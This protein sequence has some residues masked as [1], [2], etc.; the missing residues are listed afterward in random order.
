MSS[1]FDPGWLALREPADAAARSA[2]LVERTAQTLAARRPVRAVDLA[3]GTGANV[4]F[5]VPRLPS[6]QEWLL[7]D[8]DPVLLAEATRRTWRPGEG[9]FTVRQVDLG[10]PD[11]LVVIDQRDLVTAAALLDLVSDEW[12]H[13]TLARCREG[14]TVVLFALS[15]DGR[16][17]CTPDD[18]DDHLVR[19]LVNRHQQRDKGF[20]PA[21]G[22]AAPTAARAHLQALRYEV[23]EARSDWTLDPA[24]TALQIRLIDGW[25]AAAA[26]MSAGNRSRI[27]GWR[28]RRLAHVEAGRSRITVGHRDV[29]GWPA[30]G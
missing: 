11:R 19:E 21:L 4:R 20:G 22:P 6:P 5:L 2:A 27:E 16:T 8:H 10:G 25:A 26:A 28:A 14:G 1:G 3:C 18:P 23:R 9:G 7:V 24:A 17:T 15:Y 12:L 29:A 13:A 30:S